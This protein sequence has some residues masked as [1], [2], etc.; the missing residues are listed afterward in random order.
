[1]LFA[2]TTALTEGSFNLDTIMMQ[3]REGLV[4]ADNRRCPGADR[5]GDALAFVDRDVG[6]SASDQMFGGTDLVHVP[7]WPSGFGVSSGLT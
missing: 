3:Q 7:I 4:A 1:M 2:F 5:A 6:R